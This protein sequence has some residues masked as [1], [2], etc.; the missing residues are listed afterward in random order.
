MKSDQDLAT[1]FSAFAHPSRVA[2]LR[3]LLPSGP[4]GQSFGGLAKALAMSPST[5]THHLREME[6]AG[7]LIRAAE[8]RA[9]R[10][11]LNLDM[12]DEAV[13][14]LST[15]CC[16]ASPQNTKPEGARP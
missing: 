12:L 14:Q 16:C 2:I 3:S 6:Q 7:V 1:L 10:L 4:A 9:T 8:G 5:L 13:H 15:L 11:R